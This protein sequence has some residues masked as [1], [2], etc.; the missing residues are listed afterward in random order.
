MEIVAYRCVWDGEPGWMQYHDKTDPLPESWDDDEHPDEVAALVLKIDAD[1]EIERL[2][3]LLERTAGKLA[4][5][6]HADGFDAEA[7][8]LQD[9]VLALRVTNVRH[10]R[11]TTVGE[12]CRWLSARWMG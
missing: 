5:V 10:E 9:E 7:Q 8:A 6:A 2:T 4:A 12:A 1:I 11:Q 3:D